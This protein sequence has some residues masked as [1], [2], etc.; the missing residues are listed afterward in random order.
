MGRRRA[1][2]GVILLRQTAHRGRDDADAWNV[3]KPAL[4]TVRMLGREL[5]ARADLACPRREH[6]DRP[7][8]AFGHSCADAMRFAFS[9]ET[10]MVEEGSRLLRATLLGEQVS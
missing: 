1:R 2:T 10:R 6:L 9:C 5:P 7:G 4:E 8:D 3:G